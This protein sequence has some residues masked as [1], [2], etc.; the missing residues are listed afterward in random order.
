MP[1]CHVHGHECYSPAECKRGGCLSNRSYIEE[2]RRKWE[3]KR[4]PIESSSSDSDSQP[5]ESKGEEVVGT[6]L[7]LVFVVA[8]FVSIGKF[9]DPKWIIQASIF[10]HNYLLSI[11]FLIFIAYVFFLAFIVCIK[12]EW[13]SGIFLFIIVS[14]F[15]V[16]LFWVIDHSIFI[17][18]LALARKILY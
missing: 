17:Q 2:E 18:L 9:I 4:T 3:K 5:E 12:G 13:L 15:T 10:M 11:I 14:L 6:I 7:G 8:L 16:F 1:K